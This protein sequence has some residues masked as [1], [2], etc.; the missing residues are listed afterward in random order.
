MTRTITIIASY[1]RDTVRSED[2]IEVRRGGPAYFIARALAKRGTRFV[3]HTGETIDVDIA[4]RD[5]R[6]LSTVSSGARIPNTATGGPVL[7]STVLREF[8]LPSLTGRYA[9]DVQGYVRDG[10]KRGGKRRFSEP[11]LRRA[12]LIKA[13]REELAWI[14]P[15]CI[16][17][18]AVLLITDGSRGFEVRGPESFRVRTEPIECADTVGAG[19]TLFAVFAAELLRGST[20]R[21]AA[22][23]A[24]VETESFLKGPRAE[25]PR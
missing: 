14:D 15:A 13:T 18:T 19:D 25:V 8:D 20:L 12:W 2:S 23:R 16:A 21:D 11:A 9:I 6:E 4:V 7:V 22:E 3:V 17:D 1:A 5:G 10:A 24:R